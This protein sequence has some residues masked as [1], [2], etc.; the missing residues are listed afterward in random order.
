MRHAAQAKGRSRKCPEGFCSS[1]TCQE[2]FTLIEVLAVVAIMTL[3]ASIALPVLKRPPDRVAVEATAR[4][5][6]AV[7]R[8]AHAQAISSNK[9]TLVE[10]DVESRRVSPPSGS[11]IPLPA[12]MSMTVVAARPERISGSA[13]G[14]RFFPDGTSTGGD[15][16]LALRDRRA[17][18]SVNW[19]TGEATL[20]LL[21][22]EGR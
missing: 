3:V 5:V 10:I 17:K 12:D 7:M 15:V 19:L 11:Q 13:L 18:I 9:E 20:D 21:S 14:L 16:V 6:A 2:G 22:D 4:R 1:L 8:L